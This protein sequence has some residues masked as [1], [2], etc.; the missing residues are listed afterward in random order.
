MSTITI[1]DL[2]LAELTDLYDTE[3]QVLRELPLLAANA[4][5]AELRDAFDD[6]Y[7]ETQRHLQ[8]LDAIFRR[9]EERPRGANCRAVR[10]IIEDA[11]LRNG[12]VD[13]G[14]ALDGALIAVGQ[15]IE[16]YEIAG[17][18]CART[19]AMTLDD[20]TGAE[21]LQE[22]LEEEGGMDR[23]LVELAMAG[24][25]TATSHLRSLSH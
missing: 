4:T 25:L 13:R 16:H 8:R 18:R 7:R 10:A 19:Y 6:H 9:L 3:Q 5:A 12:Q 23:K 17:Y 14:T 1:R 22:T 2:Y 21:E 11:R 15:H 20:L 24:G